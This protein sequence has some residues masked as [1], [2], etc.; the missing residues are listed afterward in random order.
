MR[1]FLE[2]TFDSSDLAVIGSVLEEWR[3]QRG[4]AKESPDVAIAAAVM[5]NLFREGHDT[6]V[7]LK[8]AVSDHK[9]LAELV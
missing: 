5:I 1:S 9:G 6:T 8:R 2:T 4:L 3:I 7:A